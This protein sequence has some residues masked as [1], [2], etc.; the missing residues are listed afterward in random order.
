MWS[1]RYSQSAVFEC[2]YKRC[3]FTDWKVMWSTRYSQRA[4]CESAYTRCNLLYGLE[5]LIVTGVLFAKCSLKPVYKKVLNYGLQSVIMLWHVSAYCHLIAWE[6]MVVYGRSQ[7]MGCHNHYRHHHHHHHQHQQNLEVFAWQVLLL[8]RSLLSS[9]P[10]TTATTKQHDGFFCCH[11]HYRHHQQQQ[12]QQQNLS[13][14]C[15]AGSA[16]AGWPTVSTVK[17][18]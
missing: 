1:T 18:S 16:A 11:D 13:C 9:S 7:S 2:V 6:V 4:L 14:H 12:Q 3:Y 15:M 10:S 5:S 8:S 17:D